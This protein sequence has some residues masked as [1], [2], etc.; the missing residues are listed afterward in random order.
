M[1]VSSLEP[2][3][4]ISLLTTYQG[5]FK[6]AIKGIGV[7]KA[8]RKHTLRPIEPVWIMPTKGHIKLEVY[9][10]GVCLFGILLFCCVFSPREFYFKE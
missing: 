6:A 1:L 5:S 3:A 4:I 7:R 2:L 8:E 10:L 9:A